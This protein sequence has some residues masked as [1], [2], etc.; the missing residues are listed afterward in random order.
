MHELGMSG[1]PPSPP[2][3]QHHTWKSR[4]RSY[5]AVS[6]PRKG[7]GL[8]RMLSSRTCKLMLPSM[9]VLNAQ[10]SCRRF[11]EWGLNDLHKVL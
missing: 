8:M 9:G 6:E 1:R 5:I 10:Y 2:A 11:A 4:S 7:T 3:L